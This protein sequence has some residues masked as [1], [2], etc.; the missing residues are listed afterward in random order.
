[1][2]V[3]KIQLW[4]NVW[5]LPLGAIAPRIDRLS[6]CSV[7]FDWAIW[8]NSRYA[9]GCRTGGNG[10]FTAPIGRSDA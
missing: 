6:K 4:G 7:P 10:E 8:S 5:P 3:T 2:I 1:M 9:G